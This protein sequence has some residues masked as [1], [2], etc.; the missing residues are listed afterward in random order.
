MTSISSDLRSR[1][2][3]LTPTD[4]QRFRRR[5]AGAER[6]P[7]PERRDIVLN[8][9]AGDIDVARRR[10]DGRRAAAPRK[11]AYPAELPIT[12][13]RQELLDTIRHHQVVIVA[14]ETG[15]GKST[16]LPKLCLELGRGIEG[17][18]GHT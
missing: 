6:I 7:D 18:I 12:E 9:I 4:R 8:T 17:M 10:I 3:G 13:R 16:Q 2:D 5:L 14:G 15:S 1:L 11:L